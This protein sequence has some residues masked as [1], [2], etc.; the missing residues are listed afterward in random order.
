MVSVNVIGVKS[1]SGE[2]RLAV[3]TEFVLIPV[4]V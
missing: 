3:S 1:G 2:G 4:M